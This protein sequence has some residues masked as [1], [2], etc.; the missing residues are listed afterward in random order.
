MVNVGRRQ[1]LFRQNGRQS[2]GTFITG[3][4]LL[5]CKKARHLIY[6]QK[7]PFQFSSHLASFRETCQ[8]PVVVGWI[9]DQSPL[10]MFNTTNKTCSTRTH[11]NGCLSGLSTYVVLAYHPSNSEDNTLRA[12]TN[13][14]AQQ[15]PS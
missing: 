2:N 11:T 12:N 8:L 6:C 9:E 14:D 5:C 7:C 15:Q 4:K 10:V 1:G 3:R 13:D